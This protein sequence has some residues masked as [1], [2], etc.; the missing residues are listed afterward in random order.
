MPRTAL[1]IRAGICYHVINLGNPRATV[2]HDSL[3][4]NE[5][6]ST[7]PK[8]VGELTPELAHFRLSYVPAQA[9][10][11]LDRVFLR[12]RELKLAS[13]S[14]L[15]APHRASAAPTRADQ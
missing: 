2:F 14:R 9:G 11:L 3:D 13:D 1:S 12:A 4:T 8:N 10:G 7:A 5:L 6:S 15:P